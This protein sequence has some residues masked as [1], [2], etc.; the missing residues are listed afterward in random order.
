MEG[1]YHPYR[2]D[3]KAIGKLLAAAFENSPTHTWALP[4]KSLVKKHAARCFEIQTNYTFRCGNIIATSKNLEGILAYGIPTPAGPDFGKTWDLIRSGGLYYL[5]TS[6][7]M[8]FLKRWFTVTANYDKLRARNISGLYYYLWNIGVHPRYQKQGHGK[9]L[10]NA[11]LAEVDA[12]KM[13]CYLE[14]SNEKNVAYYRRW[15]F[16]LVEAYPVPGTPFI[17]HAMKRCKA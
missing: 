3:A 6:W 5:F 14:T 16:E 11:F 9:Q 12:A 13:P 15:N 8:P 17:L 1:V 4:D 7:G 2:K 10:M